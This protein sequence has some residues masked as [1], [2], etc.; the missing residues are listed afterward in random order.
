ME[1]LVETNLVPTTTSQPLMKETDEIVA[2]TV[3]SIK[4]LRQQFHKQ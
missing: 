4:T 3:A 2:M 1:I